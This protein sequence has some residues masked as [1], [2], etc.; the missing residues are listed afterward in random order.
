MKV[1]LFLATM[2]LTTLVNA[3]DV[4]CTWN[5]NIAADGV[6]RYELYYSTGT[7]VPTKIDIAAPLTEATIPNLI[8]GSTY[9]FYMKAANALLISAASPPVVITL[10]TPPSPPTGLKVV[11]I[12]QVSSNKRD[13]RTIANIPVEDT[14]KF[15]K[16]TITKN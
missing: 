9:T 11:V 6:V 15:V 10:P 5:A 8:A 3:V 14:D 7:A 1:L 12:V 4:K 16:A 2:F 13:W